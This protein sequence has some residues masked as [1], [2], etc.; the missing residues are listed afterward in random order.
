MSERLLTPEEMA[1][2]LNVPLSWV[3]SQTRQKGEG[4]IP[5]VRVG[6]YCRFIESHVFEWLRK[7]QSKIL[8]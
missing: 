2:K 8:K 4:T 5:V 7:K 3:Y 6:K 1:E